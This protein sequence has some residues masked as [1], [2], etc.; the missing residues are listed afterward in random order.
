VRDS[1][2]AQAVSPR[3]AILVVFLLWPSLVPTAAEGFSL[4]YRLVDVLGATGGGPGW[5][6]LVADLNGDGNDDLVRTG[7]GRALCDLYSHSRRSLETFRDVT[8]DP[9][10]IVQALGDAT[11]DGYPDLLVVAWHNGVGWVS[12][13]DIHGTDGADRPIWTAGPYLDSSRVMPKIG[14]RGSVSVLGIFDADAD[15]RREVYVDVQPCIPG[16]EPRKV[17]CLDGPTGKERWRCVVAAGIT[18]LQLLTRRG[19][20]EKHLILQ[21]YAPTNGFV[22]GNETDSRAYVTSLSPAG[23]REWSIALGGVFAW[24]YAGFGDLDGDG[25]HEIISVTTVTAAELEEDSTAAPRL[26]VIDPV[27]GKILRSVPLASGFVPRLADLDGDGRD[28]I[29]GGGQDQAVYCYDHD[30]SLRWVN[31]QRPLRDVLWI[32]D[33]DG[34]GEPEVVAASLNAI[35]ILDAGGRLLLET[36]YPG[37]PVKVLPMRIEGRTRVLIATSAQERL[38]SLERPDA[39]PVALA[40][41]GGA[42][43][44]G[45]GGLGYAV[46]RRRRGE[47]L[48]ERGEGQ[49]RLL[50]AMMAFGHAGSSLGVLHR[51][52]LHL[53]NW[54][55]VRERAA[56]SAAVIPLLEDFENS[57]LPALVRLTALARRA[58]AKPPHWRPLAGRALIVSAEVHEL[59]D[60]DDSEEDHV[61][62]AQAALEQVDACLAGLRVH[63]KQ[64]FRA[65][66]GPALRRA[67]ARHQEA[68]TAAGVAV[69]V[70]ADCPGEAAGFI[71]PP[72]LDDVLDNLVDNALRAMEGCATPRLLF[73]TAFEGAYCRIDVSDTGRGIGAADYERLF[74][75]DYSTREGGGFGLFFARQILARYEGKI[76]VRRSAPGEGTTFRVLVRSA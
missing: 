34:D 52:Q 37:E 7:P 36:E 29:L 32:A 59:L 33:M 5:N 26:S 10:G 45:A 41:A 39:S 42:L 50:E 6:T 47:Q 51:L 64:V 60:G 40:M 68:L 18:G 65:P 72:Q 15:G 46:R 66:I 17:I 63:L 48:V 31:R 8:L 49:D 75:R 55:R 20:V 56:A 21:S 19:G 2:E 9:S 57:V 69:E 27:S 30:L 58:E 54:Q 43:A 1:I 13:H 24:A 23:Q 35:G 22:A 28:E 25:N 11:G 3:T 44:V 61:H 12:C 70:R 74:D 14:T 16:G 71:S 53:K 62:R 76:F 73:E 38:V 4:R 67:L